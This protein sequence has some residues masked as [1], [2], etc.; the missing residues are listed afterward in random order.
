MSSPFPPLAAET[1]FPESPDQ[2]YF[3]AV[4]EIFARHRGVPLILSPADWQVAHGW[5]ESGVPFELIDRVFG[6]VLARRKERGGK[7]RVSSLRYFAPAVESGWQEIRELQ[8]VGESLPAPALDLPER[9]ATLAA[10]L[11]RT[12]AAAG[13]DVAQRVRALAVPSAHAEGIERE[14]ATLDAEMLERADRDL[15]S[16][17]L[18]AVAADVERS[19]KKLAA[20]LPSEEIEAA[21]ERLRRQAVRRRTRLPLLSLFSPDAESE[22]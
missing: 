10:A 6:E 7:G 21:R 2:A 13:R 8:A 22:G 14:L 20:R 16:E 9:L 12:P 15:S 17:G 11:D 3:R 18:A 4:E 19:L 1:L 5:F